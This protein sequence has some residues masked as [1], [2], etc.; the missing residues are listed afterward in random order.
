MPTFSQSNSKYPLH[1]TWGTNRLF[2]AANGQ[3][4]VPKPL[5][6]STSISS[7]YYAQFLEVYA[8]N[9]VLTQEEKETGEENRNNQQ[10]YSWS[11]NPNG[12]RDNRRGSWQGKFLANFKRGNGDNMGIAGGLN[13]RAA[14]TGNIKSFYL[15]FF[16][17][18]V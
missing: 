12:L 18:A 10:V 7:Q 6:Y 2:V 4:P 9:Q 11:K 13:D 1:P 17:I 15:T 14:I 8:K 3:L 5:P 16:K